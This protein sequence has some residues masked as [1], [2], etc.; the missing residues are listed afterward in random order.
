MNDAFVFTKVLD[1]TEARNQFPK[2]AAKARAEG[3]LS[4]IVFAGPHR[5]PDLTIMPTSLFEILAPYLEDILIAER[6]RARRVEF[7]GG[8][9]SLNELED[10]LGISDDE[11]EHAAAYNEPLLAK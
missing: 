7:E 8:G 2:L 9:L 3:P 6:V 4:T 5:N 1:T 10:H 11:V